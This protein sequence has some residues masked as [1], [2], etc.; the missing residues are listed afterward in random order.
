MLIALDKGMSVTEAGLT[1]TAALGVA[2]GGG[3]TKI[4]PVA[5]GWLDAPL[6]LA[7]QQLALPH[8]PALLHAPSLPTAA[9]LHIWIKIWASLSVPSALPLTP[10]VL[11]ACH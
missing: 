2:F 4:A 11:L 8:A 7:V 10:C 6:P 5:T 1:R 3:S 9:L